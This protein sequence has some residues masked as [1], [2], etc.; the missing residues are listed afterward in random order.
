MIQKEVAQRIAAP[1]GS[2]TNGILSILLQAFFEIEY[3][4][5]VEPGEFMP[6]PK[7]HSAV[8]RLTRNDRNQLDC[9]EKLFFRIVKQGFQ[10]RRKTLRNAL[11]PINLPDSVRIDPI[12]DKRAEAL[13]VDDFVFLTRKIE[14]EWNK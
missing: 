13:S 2:K 3:L 11:K 9:D 8:I 6:P 5:T 14:N 7:V 10:N 4:F 12:L 1:P